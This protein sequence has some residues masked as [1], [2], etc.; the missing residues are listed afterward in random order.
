L[1]DGRDNP[2]NKLFA[3]AIA[4]LVIVALTAAAAAWALMTPT[5]GTVQ[6]FDG[7]TTS[8]WVID[9]DAEVKDGVLILGGNKMTWAR[10]ADDFSPQF[11]LNLE[12]STDNNQP[13]Q[14]ETH[15]RHLFGHGSSSSS[16]NRNSKKPGEWIEAVVTGREDAAGNG[17]RTHSKWRV[18]GEPAFAD[19]PL[20]GSGSVPNSAFVAFEIPAGQK[21]SLRNVR[22]K[23]EPSTTFAWLLVLIAAALVVGVVIAVTA[24]AIMRKQRALT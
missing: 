20:G 15:H 21:L 14:L 1:L 18:V 9:G 7:K 19:Q 3:I 12:Y 4:A 13:I 16:L 2:M 8:G 24:W 23:T 22:V 10:M 6:L 5:E 11:E 17:W